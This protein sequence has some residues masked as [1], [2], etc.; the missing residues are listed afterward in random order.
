[1]IAKDFKARD[2]KKTD[3]TTTP[4]TFDTLL[5]NYASPA[6]RSD[7][8]KHCKPIATFESSLTA[9]DI[10]R[11]SKPQVEKEKGIKAEEEEKYDSQ[12][13]EEIIDHLVD[14]F[15]ISPRQI[16]QILT[17]L[18]LRP[19]ELAVAENMKSFLQVL[20]GDTYHAA[21]YHTDT[22]QG[23][24]E[25]YATSSIDQS[26]GEIGEAWIAAPWDQV[27]PN[28][29]VYE[30]FE[31]ITG[32]AGIINPYD[33]EQNQEASAMPSVTAPI[34]SEV[35]IKPIIPNEPQADETEF[36][37][38]EDDT[39]APMFGV[40]EAA[41]MFSARVRGII[42]EM[43]TMYIGEEEYEYIDE[44]LTDT[45]EPLRDQS[46][47][48]LEALGEIGDSLPPQNEEQIFS[49]I[50]SQIGASNQ[51]I[52]SGKAAA[53]REVVTPSRVMEQIV[54][55]MQIA[56]PAPRTSEIKMTLKPESLGDVTLRVQSENGLISAQFLAENQR[57]KEIMESGLDSLRNALQSQGVNVNQL[58]VSVGQEGGAEYQNQRGDVYRQARRIINRVD[59]ESLAAGIVEPPSLYMYDSRVSFTA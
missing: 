45:V 14:M 20:S 40:E 9:T 1:M 42:D 8:A 43:D 53:H 59:T 52:S 16:D 58:S 48:D 25:R 51:S 17:E 2:Y 50:N 56:D 18:N 28:A 11:Q 39:L 26:T 57:V 4:G 21:P 38:R 33:S 30:G 41:E 54:E 22:E 29:A 46:D 34:D 47:D 55:R 36:S 32:Y 19:L 13:D 12:A 27:P 5:K 10:H 35:I 15:C 44:S 23:S 24:T 31:D 3:K 6:T 49:Q 7:E 37:P